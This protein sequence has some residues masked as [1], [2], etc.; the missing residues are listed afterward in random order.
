MRVCVDTWST[1][2]KSAPPATPK[3]VLFCPQPSHDTLS[4]LTHPYPSYHTSIPSYTPH[5]SCHTPIFPDTP[6]SSRHT[7]ILPFFILCAPPTSA[8]LT[9]DSSHL[10]ERT[11]ES[12]HIITT[13]VSNLELQPSKDNVQRVVCSSSDEELQL[14]LAEVGEG[15]GSV[16]CGCG[17][18]YEYIH[19]YVHTYDC[20]YTYVHTYV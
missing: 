10:E 11:A 16:G 12:E 6:H 13:L 19:T 15:R 18:R 1:C 20:V 17:R 2:L 5:S 8:Y 7:P 3:L 4:Y 14:Q 9:E